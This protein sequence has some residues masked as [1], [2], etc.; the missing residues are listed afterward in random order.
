MR[1]DSSFCAKSVRYNIFRTA[2]HTCAQSF[3]PWHQATINV[4]RRNLSYCCSLA[5][6][7]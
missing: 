6:H 3:A 7:I 1:R 2:P 4:M 5:L